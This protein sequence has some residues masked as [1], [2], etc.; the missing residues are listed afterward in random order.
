MFS[1]E[2]MTVYFSVRSYWQGFFTATVGALSWR[3]M[4]MWFNSDQN[5]THLM[6]THFRY[7]NPYEPL[8]IVSFIVLGILCG[9]AANAFVII[10]QAT[11]EFNR[12]K[13]KWNQL[14]QRFPL[15]YPL[16]LSTIIGLISYPPYFGKYYGSWMS[17]GNAC[18]VLV[19]QFI[20]E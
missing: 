9:L 7:E 4:V 12:R 8:E 14:L 2:I 15:L 13:T 11:V 16:L 19:L 20:V 18:A 6:R 10:H 17:A 1:I 3:L 5:L